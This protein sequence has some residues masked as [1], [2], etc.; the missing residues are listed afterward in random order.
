MNLFAIRD[1]LR[2]HQLII[3]IGFAIV[4]ALLLTAISVSLYV[5]SGASRLDLSRPGYEGVR[6]RISTTNDDD[7]FSASGPM[8]ANVVSDFETIFSKKRKTVNTLDPFSPTVLD[9]DSIRLLNST[10]PQL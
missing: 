2:D 4:I 7:N 3:G 5:R 9:D 10:E 1:F 8:S 6:D